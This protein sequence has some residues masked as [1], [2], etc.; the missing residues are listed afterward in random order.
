MCKRKWYRKTE[1]RSNI[2]NRIEKLTENV[3]M[4]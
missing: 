2:E 1:M 3:K 4:G